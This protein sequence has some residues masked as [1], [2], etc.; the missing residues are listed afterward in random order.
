MDNTRDRQTELECDPQAESG[1]LGSELRL[2]AN[3]SDAGHGDGDPV[4][5]VDIHRGHADGHR[6]Q[7][8]SRERGV[9][10]GSD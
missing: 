10:L 7:T 4:S 2:W 9:R 8:Q 6:V 3:L 5:G 1:Y